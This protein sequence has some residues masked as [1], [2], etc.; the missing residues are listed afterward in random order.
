MKLSTNKISEQL[1][2]KNGVEWRL[3]WTLLKTQKRQDPKKSEE[4]RKP[5]AGDWTGHF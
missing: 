4:L 3:D 1:K 5:R 2:Q